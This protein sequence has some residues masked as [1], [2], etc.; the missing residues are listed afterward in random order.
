[1]EV[2]VNGR[3]LQLDT[4][5]SLGELLAQLGHGERRVAV[6]VNREIVPRSQHASYRLGDGD[7]VELVH[8]MG[9]G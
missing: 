5:I 2:I 6:E 9:G 8:A 4:P 3:A 7:R 1:M